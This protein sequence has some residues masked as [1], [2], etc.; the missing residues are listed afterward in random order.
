LSL[1]RIFFAPAA[2]QNSGRAFQPASNGRSRRPGQQA[3]QSQDWSNAMTTA[4]I[5]TAVRDGKL[6][7]QQAAALLGNTQRTPFSMK[8]SEKGAVSMKG[9]P[10][11]HSRMGLTL[12]VEA[13]EFL[14][15]RADEI[16]GWIKQHDHKLSRKRR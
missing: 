15:D 10:G 4:E 8:V 13:L 9:I 6:D 16:R 2:Q 3:T 5:L 1:A 12:Y 7:P 14:L 11:T